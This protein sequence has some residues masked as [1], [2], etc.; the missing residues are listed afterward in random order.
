VE[1]DYEKLGAFYLGREVDPGSGEV[2]DEVVL[3]DSKDL[4]TH[5]V[6]IGMTGSGKT[7]LGIGILEEAA[8]DRIPV[9]AVDPKGDM[10]NLLLTFPDLGAGD[11]RPWIN[12]ETARQKGM[13]PDA[14]AAKEAENWRKGLG[15]WDQD[16]QRIRRLRE[17]ADFAIYTPG[18]SA[19]L[20]V[21]VLRSFDA[22]PKALV[23]D[24]D[25]FRERIQSTVAGLLGL[26]GIDADPIRSREHI[27]LSSILDDAWRKG[28]S[29]DLGALIQAIQQPPFTR[30]GVMELESVYPAKD[31]FGLAMQLNALIASP[32]FQGWMEGEPLDI[33]SMLYTPEGKPRLTIFSIAHLGDAERMFF[34]TM[35]LSAVLGW[36]R[37]QPGTTSLRA[38]VYMDEIFGFFPPVANPPSKVPMLTLLKQARAFGVGMVLASQNPVDLDY[39]GLGNT[40]TWFIGRLQTERDKMRVLEALDGAMAGSAPIPRGELDRMISGLGKRVFLMHNVHRGAPRL[41]TTRWVMSY[42]AGPLTLTQVRTLMEPRKAGAGWEEGAAASPVGTLPAPP[43]GTGAESN[44]AGVRPVLPPEIRQFFLPPFARG[45]GMAYRPAL[46]ATAEVRYSSARHGV[47]ESRSLTLLSPLE[48]GP[49]PFSLD[50]TITADLSADLLDTEPLDGV[51]F[52]TLPPDGAQPRSYDRWGKELVR[53][54][55]GAHPITL[56]ES[57]AHKVFSRVGESERDFRMRLADLGREARDVQADRLRQKYEPRFRTLQD[58]LRRAEQAVQKREAQS[59]QAMLNT[60]LSTLGAVLGAATSG[61]GSRARGGLLGAFLGGGVSKATTAMRSAGR[62]AQ[63]RQDVSHAE[64]TV[65]AVQAQLEALE[66]EFQAE[67]RRVEDSADAAEALEEVVIRPP[68]NGISLRLTALVWLPWGVDGTGTPTPLWR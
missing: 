55:Q 8:M 49:I 11:F 53:W 68:L 17:H 38:L 54:V 61:K 67:L 48:D 45:E 36:M 42:L 7:G 27:L 23:D 19:G 34:V 52:A 35:L 50:R 47:E 6:I 14:F 10:T 15:D 5:G 21:S 44:S 3:Y 40:G 39:K 65:E 58:R 9:L 43:S 59:R 1:H 18:S 66:A 20:P 46:L 64:E 63:T 12:E 62:A 56:Y 4:T 24:A 29:L 26:L 32:G 16:G 13:D 60:G 22:P 57:K 2:T 30:L 28:R 33:A 31:R 51:G 41:F 37:G 25:S